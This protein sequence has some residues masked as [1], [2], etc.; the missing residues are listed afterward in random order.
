MP[1]FVLFTHDCY[2][3]SEFRTIDKYISKHK[4]SKAF[5]IC[6]ALHKNLFICVCSHFF[7]PFTANAVILLSVRFNI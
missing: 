2:E 3:G 6:L 5:V 7:V 1:K 4:M